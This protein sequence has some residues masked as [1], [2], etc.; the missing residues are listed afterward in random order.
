MSGSIAKAFT[1]CSRRDCS[2]FKAEYINRHDGNYA[3]W[4][5]TDPERQKLY[6]EGLSKV[7]VRIVDTL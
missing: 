4:Y 6:K 5:S 1:T 2:I 3:R 7:K